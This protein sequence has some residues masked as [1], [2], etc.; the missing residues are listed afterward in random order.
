MS[1]EETK[2]MLLEE[3]QDAVQDFY[4]EHYA[5]HNEDFEAEQRWEERL[6]LE[7]TR[8]IILNYV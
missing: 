1:K 3:N 2:V 4:F 5:A 7:E 6:T 8:E